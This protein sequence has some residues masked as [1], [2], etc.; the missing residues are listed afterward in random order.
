MRRLLDR[1]RDERDVN[2]SAW[3][4]RTVSEALRAEFA[5]ESAAPAADASASAGWRPCRV[6]QGWGSVLDGPAVARLPRQL[7]GMRIAVIDS[8]GASWTSTVEEVVSRSDTRVVVR[9]SG[10]PAGG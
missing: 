10:R 8:R 2:V 4:R 7:A 5:D 1:L 6:G 3:V 9:D